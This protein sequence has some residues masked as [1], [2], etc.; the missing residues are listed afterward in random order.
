MGWLVGWLVGVPPG[1]LIAWVLVCWCAGWLV[2]W[3]V[4]LSGGRSFGLLVG[5]GLV[6]VDRMHALEPVGCDLFCREMHVPIVCR[7]R[8]SVLHGVGRAVG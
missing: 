1:L 3:L 5:Q 2:G 8:F 7:S 4:F 6:R